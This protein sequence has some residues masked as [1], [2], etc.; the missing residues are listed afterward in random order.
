MAN[1]NNFSKKEKLALI[2]LLGNGILDAYPERFHA[3]NSDEENRHILAPLIER[4]VINSQEHKLRELLHE[5]GFY[6]E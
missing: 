1:F 4:E 2:Y 5:V 6:S 3:D